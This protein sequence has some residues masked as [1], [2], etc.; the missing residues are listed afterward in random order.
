MK[1]KI[2]F[3][4]GGGAATE[5]L[6]RFLSNKYDLYFGDACVDSIDDRIPADRKV[7]LPFANDPQFLSRL[8][9]ISDSLQLDMI[10]PGVDEEL[11]VLCDNR[12]KNLPEIF[13]PPADFVRL[14]L[15]KLDCMNALQKAGLSVPQTRP[16]TEAAQIGFPLI[17]KPRSGR[18]SRGVCVLTSEQEI[19][20]YQLLYK[21]QP[22]TL[23][24]QQLGKGDEYTILVAGNRQGELTAIV[25]VLIEQKRGITIRA[26]TDL[27][28]NIIQYVKAFH[29]VF[30]P[31]GVYNIQ[32]MLTA[33]GQVLPFEINPRISTTFCLSVAAGFDP[34]AEARVDQDS[35]FLPRETICLKR[36]WFNNIYPA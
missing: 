12:H 29:A 7:S 4:G 30:K 32:C 3:T 21:A 35:I 36:N 8:A 16:I 31:H 10:V 5:A 2:L 26:R 34:F 13:A 17:V 24:A 25:P 28:E 19:A 9:E 14:M 20:A 23:L 11:P 27:N 15:D 6:W 33:D 22:E 18:G 1:K